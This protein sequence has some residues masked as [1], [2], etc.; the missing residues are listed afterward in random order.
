M[1]ENKAPEWLDVILDGKMVQINGKGEI[2][3]V[4]NDR[5]NS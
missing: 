2:R 1:D 3:E 4:Q 5:R